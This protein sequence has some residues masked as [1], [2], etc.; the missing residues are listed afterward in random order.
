MHRKILGVARINAHRIA[1]KPADLARNQQLCGF[2][3]QAGEM[4]LALCVESAVTLC[5]GPS[6]RPTSSEQYDCASR[7]ASMVLFPSFD[8]VS[9]DLIVRIFLSFGANIDYHCG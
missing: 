8:A 9:R 3:R 4:H 1:T 7:N 6:P 2:G 5:I